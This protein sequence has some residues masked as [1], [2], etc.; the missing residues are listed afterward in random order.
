MM[1]PG[2]DDISL[3]DE[4]WNEIYEELPVLLHEAINNSRG[5]PYLAGIL[6]R[7]NLRLRE[8][9]PP[10]GLPKYFLS[11]EMGYMIQLIEVIGVGVRSVNV[12]GN[13]LAIDEGG[14]RGT[15]AT[16][17]FSTTMLLNSEKLEER[18]PG[19]MGRLTILSGVGLS[20]SELAQQMFRPEEP[21]ADD[22]ALP[23]GLADCTTDLSD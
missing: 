5:D 8:K 6:L 21:L 10:P 3:I 4:Q 16:G 15:T 7:G 2:R 17:L 18:H 12:R 20:G 23:A 1:Q 22:L 13:C 14:R 19:I 11:A 9:L